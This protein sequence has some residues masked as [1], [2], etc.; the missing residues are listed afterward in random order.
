MRRKIVLY[1]AEGAGTGV[2]EEVLRAAGCHDKYR[3]VR[4]DAD[5]DEAFFREAE[6]ADGVILVY[7]D[8]REQNLK[9][10][11]NC[12]VLAVHAVG[13]NNIDLKAA[14]E[15]GVCV[16]NTPTYC[17]DEVAAHTVA[18]ALDG[19]RK[20]SQ[21]NLLVRQGRW[22][23]VTDCGKMRGTR[24]MTYG[25]VSFGNIPRR[26]PELLKPFGMRF[27]A[28]DPHVEDGILAEFGVERAESLESL[29]ARS[30]CVSVHSPLLPAT[31]RMISKAQFDAAKP[32]L[33]L[34]VTG[35]GGVVDEAALRDALLDGRVSFAGL[36]VLE[37]ELPE[38]EEADGATPL[39]GLD[40]VVITPHIAYYTEDSLDRC[41]AQAMEQ[42]VSVLEGGKLPA[43][44]VNKEVDGR[45]RFQMA[46]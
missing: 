25:L 2:E 39:A 33:V 42:V 8:L 26:I 16:C 12:K 17:V 37:S 6:D 38:S 5:D 13:F 30:D 9:R 40:N 11:K 35:R 18:L 36:D 4:M 24:G 1:K 46:P 14:T 45:A 15:L 22:P 3:L 7:T 28:Y 43:H 32:G 29:F 27:I 10:L 19:I 31:R 44:L 34:V 21:M 23:Y 20:I 41:R